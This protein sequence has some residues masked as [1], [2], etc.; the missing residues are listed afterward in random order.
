[1]VVGDL[2]KAEAY[3]YYLNLLDTVVAPKKLGLFGRTEVDFDRIYHLTGGRIYFIRNYVAQV[4]SFGPIPKATLFMMVSNARTTFL[5][6]ELIRPKI[7]STNQ[8]LEVFKML[9]SSQS[10]YLN[11][12]VVTA[13]F[14]EQMVVEEMIH[15]NILHF[16][17]SS[18]FARDLQPIPEDDVVTASGHPA[19]R[20]MELLIKDW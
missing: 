16:R 3:Q 19:L 18:D 14:K 11:Y 7:F 8:V 4:C 17:P 5:R 13:H 6:R 10:G 15:R 12:E 1:M 20:A 9:T 2:T